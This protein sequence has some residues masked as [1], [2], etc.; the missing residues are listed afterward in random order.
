M[1]RTRTLS[2]LRTE[3]REE[4]GMENSAFVTDAEV[5]RRINNRIAALYGK[6]VKARGEQFYRTSASFS[7]VA[8]TATV[9]LPTDFFKLLGLD[10]V[11]GSDTF[12]PKPMNWSR[13]NDF[14]DVSG[15]SSHRS[16]YYQI[17]KAN[18][19]FWPTPEAIYSGTIWYL[20][21]ATVLASGSETFDGINGWERWV[22][23]GVV[24]ALLRKEES[25]VSAHLAE[26]AEIDE[27]IA[28]LATTRDDDGAD[29]PRDVRRRYPTGW[30]E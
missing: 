20:P 10:V 6:L 5:D 30:E 29:F 12:D 28:A 25:D 23:L 3:A 4:A 27:Q 24:I 13:R 16:I 21:H 7:T 11:I 8:N 14:Q 18:L 2:E 15:W 22:V 19:R 26:L 1:A 17:E 9:A